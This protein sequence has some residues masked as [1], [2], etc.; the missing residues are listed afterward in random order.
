MFVLL[1]RPPLSDDG[2]ARRTPKQR[3]ARRDGASDRLEPPSAPPAR[4]PARAPPHAPGLVGVEW[5]QVFIV[6]LLLLRVE[7][8]GIVFH[9]E[10]G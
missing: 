2:A 8:Q 3:N 1:R 10:V 7:R 9:D 5:I 4:S 6:P